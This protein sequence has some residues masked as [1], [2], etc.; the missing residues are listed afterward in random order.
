MALNNRIYSRKVLW[1]LVYMYN[2][3][4][5]ILSKN[6]YLNLAEKIE[7]IVSSGLNKIS[8]EEFKK[9]DFSFLGILA[10]LPTSK[11]ISIDEYLEYFNPEF[12]KFE[13]IL[14]YVVS[15]VKKKDIDEL[16]YD[17]VVKNMKFL[18]ENYEE[19]IQQFDKFLPKFKFLELDSVVQS[20][21]LLMKA[22]AETFQ[23]PKA[24]LIKEADILADK[25][26]SSSSVGLVHAVL[27]K[28][29]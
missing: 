1:R 26:A 20:I 15:I 29:L 3:V 10:Q 4:K 12:Q 7:T 2:F 24:I 14:S 23:T 25:F 18:I 9:Y 13:E 6:I 11:E 21:L 28:V 17:Y 27:D 19:L 16:E 22:E 5:A 8:V